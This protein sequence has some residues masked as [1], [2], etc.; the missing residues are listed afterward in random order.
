VTVSIFSAYALSTQNRK[1]E[2]TV[3]KIKRIILK[4]FLIKKKKEKYQQLP[5]K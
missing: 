3:F 1:K 2:A 4:I 5:V